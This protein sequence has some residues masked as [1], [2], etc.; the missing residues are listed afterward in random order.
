MIGCIYT[1][2]LD[3]WYG[4]GMAR[5]KG[6]E[7]DSRE[8]LLAAAWE[9]M[10]EHGSAGMSV[11]AMV[12]RARLSKGTFFHFF[13]TKQVLLDA[14]SARIADESWKSVSDVLERTDLD[15]LVRLDLLLQAS[16]AWR[17]D[18]SRAIGAMWHELVREEN[19]GLM[20]KARA[21][22]IDL[23]TGAVTRLLVEANERGRTSIE[24]VE[25]VS[26]LVVE[27]TYA[28]AEGNLRLLADGRDAGAVDLA[29][30]RANAT[31]AALERVLAIEQGTFTRVPVDLLARIAAG[32]PGEEA[33]G[34]EGR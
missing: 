30:R 10:L 16:R 28:V 27:W 1:V 34:P 15:P 6:K 22:G 14:L 17:G 19:A 29:V 24:D 23:M 13:P 33:G 4:A 3:R 21:R 7:Q 2:G 31:M 32:L 18:R 11:E 25:V 26:R 5:K 8:A 20:G 12:A 9:L